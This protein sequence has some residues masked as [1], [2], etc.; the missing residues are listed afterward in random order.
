MASSIFSS[1]ILAALE[2]RTSL[3]DAAELGQL[4]NLSA[5][6]IYRKAR[7]GELPSVRFGYSVKFDPQAMARWLRKRYPAEPETVSGDDQR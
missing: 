2:G 4:L 1:R 5:K 7:T 3:M 6:S